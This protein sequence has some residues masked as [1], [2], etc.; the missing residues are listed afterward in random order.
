MSQ[1]R[2]TR[3]ELSR[4]PGSRG[5]GGPL[6]MG[7]ERKRGLGGKKMVVDLPA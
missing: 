5:E 3:R 4:V 1:G 6:G 7:E 2:K